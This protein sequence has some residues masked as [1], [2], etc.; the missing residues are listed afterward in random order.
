MNG[1]EE[2]KGGGQVQDA[3]KASCFPCASQCQAHRKV[4]SFKGRGMS[5]LD[6]Y[7]LMARQFLQRHLN[8][9]LR[10]PQNRPRLPEGLARVC[11]LCLAP[12]TLPKVTRSTLY[13]PLLLSLPEDCCSCPSPRIFVVRCGKGAAT[14][15]LQLKAKGSLKWAQTVRQG[16]ETEESCIS[17]RPLLLQWP[18]CGSSS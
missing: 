10:E 4:S 14:Q 1:G 13:T 16:P 15:V 11:E 17:L 12:E 3:R 18:P 6:S 2:R 9:G 8:P 5:A 7:M